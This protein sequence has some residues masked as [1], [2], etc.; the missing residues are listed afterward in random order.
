M[1]IGCS[2]GS[3]KWE[4]CKC[5]KCGQTRDEGHDWD[6]DCEK[7]DRC[8]L[9]RK[10]TH[11]WD[12]GKCSVCAKTRP[13]RPPRWERPDV[14][15]SPSHRDKEEAKVVARLVGYLS[16][17]FG[18]DESVQG[19]AVLKGF[20]IMGGVITYQIGDMDEDEYLGIA[21]LGVAEAGKMPLQELRRLCAQDVPMML[22]YVYF[23]ENDKFTARARNALEEIVRSGP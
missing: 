20:E 8:G 16:V 13:V 18:S 15:D 11:R 12:M 6:K 5:F 10:N 21:R 19:A 17:L 2:L 1:N 14:Y 9:V 22:K 4:G 23:F 3:H 7:C